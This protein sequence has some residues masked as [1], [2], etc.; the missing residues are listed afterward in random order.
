MQIFY[1]DLIM[2]LLKGSGSK[3]ELPAWMP[4]ET[5]LY[6]D[7]MGFEFPGYVLWTSKIETCLVSAIDKE[8]Q[9]ILANSLIR[10]PD[11]SREDKQTTARKRALKLLQGGK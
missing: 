9:L 10:K 4:G 3:S 6:S 5:V 1:S 7:A 8:R 11:L 2:N